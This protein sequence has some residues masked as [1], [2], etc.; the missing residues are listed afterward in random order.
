M[1]EFI[2]AIPTDI[3]VTTAMCIL[4]SLSVAIVMRFFVKPVLI[5]LDE[6]FANKITS[7]K[8]KAIYATIKA[9]AF[10][11]IAGILTA[12]CLAKLMTFCTFPANNAKALSFLYYIPMFALQ[13]FLDRHMKKIFCKVFGIPYEE[14]KEAPVEEEPKAPRKRINGV[15][16]IQNENGYWVPEEKEEV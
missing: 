14:T 4:A 7:E 9:F 10:V 16:Y 6:L 13:F 5:K 1:R 15:W 12:Y 3:V 11:V 2:S 8:A